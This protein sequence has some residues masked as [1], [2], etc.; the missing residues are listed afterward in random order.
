MPAE[1]GGGQPSE[2]RERGAG[3]VRADLAIRAEAQRAVS[4]VDMLTSS[5]VAG[6]LGIRGRNPREAASR[7][8]RS[9]RLLGVLDRATRSYV[10]PAFQVDAV[11]GRVHPVVEAVNQALGATEDPRGVASW[12]VSAHPRLGDRAPRA[13]VGAADE[14]DLL[15]LVGERPASEATDARDG[16][17]RR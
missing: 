12:W 5:A 11:R 6:A 4:G 7:L 1:E 10:F 15:V 9:G 17:A 3:A 13:L 8:R 14:G 16:A 2:G